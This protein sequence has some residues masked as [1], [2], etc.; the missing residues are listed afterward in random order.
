MDAEDVQ[1]IV[2]AQQ[3]LETIDAPEAQ[4]TG[5]QADH[6]GAAGADPA[7]GGGDGDQTGHRARGRA[8]QGGLALEEGLGRGPGQ[9]R[10]AGG[11]HGVEEGQGGEAVGLQVGA[12]VEAEPADPQQGG[13]DHG[14][15]QAMGRQV[16]TTVADALA[17][18]IGA[19]QTGHGG[20]DVDHGTAGEVQGTLLEEEARGGGGG[21]GRGG[22][23][24]SIRAGPVPH[25]VGHGQ[26][27]E[28]EPDDHE[29]HHRREFHALGEGADDEGGGDGGKGGLKDDV[30]EFGDVDALAEGGGHR[31]H[32]DSIEE[33]L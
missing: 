2:R 19:H 11:D 25:H 4:Q 3:A 13:T 23:G 31:F 16:L 6:Q 28:G 14:Q 24:V 33:E 27:G 30:G 12:G 17:D 18:Q 32:R 20:V 10:G 26:V 8:Q 7:G 21:L 29:Q 5:D 22:V 15:G 9:G 1:G